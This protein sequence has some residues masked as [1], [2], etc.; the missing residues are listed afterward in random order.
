MI[1]YI[2]SSKP[3]GERH[4]CDEIFVV[5]NYEDAM[6]TIKLM[7]YLQRFRPEKKVIEHIS[8]DDSEASVA[9][10]MLLEERRWNYKLVF[11]KRPTYS[12]QLILDKHPS[13]DYHVEEETE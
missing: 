4:L 6:E 9:V 5:N 7:Q 12:M 3:T 1:L 11:R 2:D 8:M 13:W 10:L